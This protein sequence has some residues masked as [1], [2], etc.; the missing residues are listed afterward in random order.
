M[1]LT[2][3]EIAP[4]MGTKVPAQYFGSGQTTLGSPVMLEDRAMSRVLVVD[5]DPEILALLMD[6]VESAGYEVDHA[7]NGRDALERVSE[8][9]PDLILTDIMMPVMDGWQFVERCRERT[10][11]R[12]VPILVLSAFLEQ[13]G[14]SERLSTLHVARSRAKP[15]DLD[16]LLADI[17]SAI[18][19]PRSDAG[20]RAA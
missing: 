16:D 2:I 9:V 17:R 4:E 3:C 11:C 7:V 1:L 18:G 15:F 5:D 19:E 13:P 8:R 6:A 14:T 10:E 12:T 20:Q